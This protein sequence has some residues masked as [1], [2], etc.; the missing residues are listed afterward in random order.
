MIVI[1]LALLA[2]GCAS[3]LPLATNH[4]LT[5]QKKIRASHHWDVIADDVANQTLVASLKKSGGFSGRTLYVQ[6]PTDNTPFNKA[7]RNF[8]ITRMVNRGMPVS[9]SKEGALEVQY[10]LQLVRHHSSR[11][12]HTPGSLTA[13]TA[14]IAVIRDVIDSGSIPTLL[15]LSALADWGLGYY[16]GGPTQLELIITTSVLN[17]GTYGLRKSDVYYI[18]DADSDLFMEALEPSEQPV[19][20]WQIV[21]K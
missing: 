13:L 2:G 18:Q 11:Y 21:G 3:Q 5:T 8:L 4:P 19:K 1:I 7:F 10:E 15:G 20:Q 12:T 16:S 14:G 17:N 6:A 9:N